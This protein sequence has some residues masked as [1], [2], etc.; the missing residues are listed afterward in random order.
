MSVLSFIE[1]G[2]TLAG[3]GAVIGLWLYA[4]RWAPPRE[5][6]Q[7][8]GDSLFPFGGRARPGRQR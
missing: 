6:A 3:I 7:L 5:V 8:L 4:A 2:L 1:T